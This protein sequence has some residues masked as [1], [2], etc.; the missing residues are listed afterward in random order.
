MHAGQVGDIPLAWVEPEAAQRRT[1]VIWLPGFSGTKEAMQ[2]YLV[3]LAAAV[4]RRIVGPKSEHCQ[5]RPIGLVQAVPKRGQR[6]RCEERH[7]GAQDDDVALEVAKRPQGDS[8]GVTRAERFRLQ[9]KLRLRTVGA[10]RREQGVGTGPVYD[11][12]GGRGQFGGGGQDV[13]NGWPCGDGLEWLEHTRTHAASGA[14]SKYRSC[15]WASD[16]CGNLLERR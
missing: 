5:G 2:P 3:D 14:A 1:L 8:R 12:G 9:G 16:H 4:A 10:N 15:E 11:H 7:V 6:V 13:E